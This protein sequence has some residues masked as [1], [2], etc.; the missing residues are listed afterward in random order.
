M[1]TFILILFAHVGSMGTGNSNA[2]TTAEFSSQKTCMVAGQAAK[3]MASGTV[4]L[5]EFVCV[6]K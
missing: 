5:I 1:G 4:K 6:P 3:S 2:M